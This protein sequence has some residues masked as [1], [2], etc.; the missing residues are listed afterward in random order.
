[1]KKINILLVWACL[2][3]FLAGC[4]KENP[5]TSTSETDVKLNL[6][7][8]QFAKIIGV[9]EALVVYN[10]K[11]SMFFY[12]EKG[13]PLKVVQDLYQKS[14]K[15]TSINQAYNYTASDSSNTINSLP[16]VNQ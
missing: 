8:E 1:M 4:Q 6:L 9:D 7:K 12:K 14:I 13:L 11:T 2:T 5:E 16:I 3:A 10:Q 15:D